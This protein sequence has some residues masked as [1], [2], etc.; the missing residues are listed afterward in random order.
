MAGKK[1]SGKSKATK[2]T[3]KDLEGVAG[4]AAGKVKGGIVRKAEPSP[5]DSLALI[6]RR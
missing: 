4:K 6:R 5:A 2:A 1:T 3:A